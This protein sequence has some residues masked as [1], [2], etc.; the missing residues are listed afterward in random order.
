M[1]VAFAH[2]G[3]MEFGEP[4][5]DARDS[6]HFDLDEIKRYWRAG[7][8]RP[9]DIKRLYDSGILTETDLEELA[10]DGIHP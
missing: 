2:W 10:H 3:F 7:V 6:L 5:Y 8:Y 1:A 9:H 4:D